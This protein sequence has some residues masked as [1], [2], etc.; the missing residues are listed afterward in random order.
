MTN[1]KTLGALMGLMLLFGW[2]TLSAQFKVGSCAGSTHATLQSAFNDLTSSPVCG[3]ATID[4]CAATYVDAP[5]LLN[6]LTYCGTGGEVIIKKSTTVPGPLVLRITS[7]AYNRILELQGAKHVTFEN[8]DFEVTYSS[9][10][11]MY[12]ML[13]LNNGSGDITFR[14]C[15]FTGFSLTGLGYVYSSGGIW[16]GIHVRDLDGDLTL[17]NCEF[18]DGGC[19]VFVWDGMPGGPDQDVFV[20]NT[21]FHEQQFTGIYYLGECDSMSITNSTFHSHNPANKYQGLDIHNMP[22]GYLEVLDSEF[23]MYGKDHMIAIEDRSFYSRIEDNWIFGEESLKEFVGVLRWPALTECTIRRN[24]IYYFRGFLPEANDSSATGIHVQADYASTG[25]YPGTQ[26]LEI[27]DNTIGLDNHKNSRGITVKGINSGYAAR[28]VV[29][30]NEVQLNGRKALNNVF[31]RGISIEGEG[32]EIGNLEVVQNKVFSN[33]IVPSITAGIVVENIEQTGQM[34]LLNNSVSFNK[35]RE[36]ST[37]IRLAHLTPSAAHTNFVGNNM[38]SLPAIPLGGRGMGIDHVARTEIHHNS[39][40]LWGSSVSATVNAIALDISGNDPF[41]TYDLGVR[42]NILSNSRGGRAIRINM[43]SGV[44][45][46]DYNLLYNGATSFLGEYA[47]TIAN[48]LTSWQSISGGGGNSVDGNPQFMGT[49]NLHINFSSPALGAASIYTYTG[50]AAMLNEDVDAETRGGL[51]GREIGADELFFL[52]KM[53]QS[54]FSP[55]LEIF[56]NPSQGRITVRLPES[57]QVWN[58][59]VLN[60]MGQTVRNHTSSAVNLK[61]DLSELPAGTYVVKASNGQTTYQQKLLLQ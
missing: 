44:Y 43:A 9:S 30:R 32:V 46:H 17:E 41:L 49:S 19:G 61:L 20:S 5:A 23:E 38:I 24:S 36:Y 55:A 59:Q 60:L 51:G 3:T 37:G 50:A 54:N 8:I 48:S 42:N 35:A 52:G 10:R 2:N 31:D 29:S 57:E 22:I 7:T 58:I 15:T 47:G 28:L 33:Y 12:W 34:V 53:G 1:I 27:T 45:S 18:Q 13:D 11:A 16:A 25:G 39:I 14:N 6:G 40:H 26:W 21:E 4:I 56:P